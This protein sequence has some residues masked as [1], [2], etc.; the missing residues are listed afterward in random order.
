ME[1]N[2]VGQPVHHTGL[3]NP[4]G[5]FYKGSHC[6]KPDNLYSSKYSVKPILLFWNYMICWAMM[7]PLTHSTCA[8]CKSF[9]LRFFLVRCA[10]FAHWLCFE[11][12]WLY[13]KIQVGM[14]RCVL[15]VCTP[16][17]RVCTYVYGCMHLSFSISVSA[18]SVRQTQIII[19][20]T[21]RFT[22]Y[23]IKLSTVS[24]ESNSREF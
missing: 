23:L 5:K 24:S 9:L 4:P 3:K 17:C 16:S 7:S 8:F 13:L 10:L 20:C 21:L 12:I 15:C 22:N 2:W 19:L 14:V 18:I 6:G 1:Y 11:C